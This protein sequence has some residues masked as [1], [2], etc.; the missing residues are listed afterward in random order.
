MVEKKGKIPV[1]ARIDIDYSGQQPKIKFGYTG[2]NPMKE[3]YKQNVVGV[4]TLIIAIGVVMLWGVLFMSGH[5]EITS[6][7]ECDTLFIKNYDDS[8]IK[9]VNF[10][11]DTGNYSVYFKQFYS[12]EELSTQ[13]FHFDYRTLQKGYT[14]LFLITFSLF[15]TL[16]FLVN[17]LVT[18]ILI[19]NKTYIQKHPINM[20][21]GKNRKKKY[22][23][24]GPKDLLEN[25]IVIPYFSNVELDYKTTGEFSKYL[26]HIKVRERRYYDYRKGKKGKLQV[27]NY[28]WHTVFIFK[29]KPTTGY[30]EVIYQ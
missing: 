16:F 6:P 10:I 15:V 26:E 8:Y 28:D 2:K 29:K 24:Y 19:N 5:F 27:K 22:Y 21:G 11:C 9:R 23:R 1:N 14:F 30:L 4:H 25:V 12:L 17:R 3:A 13:G 18:L 20:A 7:K